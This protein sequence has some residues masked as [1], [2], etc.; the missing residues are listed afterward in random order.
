MRIAWLLL[1][2]ALCASAQDDKKDVVSVVNKLFEGMAAGDADV[3]SS[4][5]TPDAKLVAAQDGQISSAITRDQFAQRIGAN[6]SRVVERIWNPTVLVRGRIAVVWADYDVYVAG[7]FGHCGIDAFT[8]L[9]TDAG[10]RISGTQYTSET[11]GCKPNPS[12][13][14]PQ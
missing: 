12:G 7:K 10:W 9:K 3:I 1:A 2:V 14:P 6:K 11:Q 8:L 13:P 4:T 5:M